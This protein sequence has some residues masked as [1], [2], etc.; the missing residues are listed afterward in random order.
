LAYTQSTLLIEGLHLIIAASLQNPS[1]IGMV[2]PVSQ[3]NTLYGPL[4][5]GPAIVNGLS[6]VPHG[7][8]DF[9]LQA[10]IAPNAGQDMT[11]VL[12]G[13]FHNALNNISTPMTAVGIGAPGVAWLDTAIKSLTL[14]TALPPLSDP[15]IESVSID[16]M[17]LDFAC[18]TCVTKPMASSDITAK[19]NLPFK[20]A[21]IKY[22]SQNIQ[23]LDKNKAVIGVLQ[24]PYAACVV[25]GNMVSTST[26]LSELVIDEAALDLIYPTFI[27]DLATGT[28]YSLGLRGTVDS[29]LDL[30]P[31]GIVEIKGIPLDVETPMA[32]LNNLQGMK[33]MYQVYSDYVARPRF[34]MLES[35]IQIHNPTNLTLNLGTVNFATAAAG[36][37]PL[38]TSTIGNLTLVPGDNVVASETYLDQSL[39]AAQ[40]LHYNLVA[41]GTNY[42]LVLTGYDQTS[43]NA[44]LNAGL[45]VMKSEVFLPG[46]LAGTNISQPPYLD[47]S[48]KT[49][50]TTNTDLTFKATATFQSPYYGFPLQMVDPGIMSVAQVFNVSFQADG[51]VLFT[52]LSGPT[53]TVQGTEQVTVTFDVQVSGQALTA[54]LKPLW[55]DIVNY[56]QA[57]GNIP[58]TFQLAADMIF[59]NNGLVEPIDISSQSLGLPPSNVAVRPDFAS[60]LDAFPTA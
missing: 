23:I 43:S 25:N 18:D 44:A 12:Q 35:I 40:T 36:E 10:T 55:V 48:L 2:I 33:Y 15:P 1:T 20:L 28:T 24:T 51:T 39:P 58:V 21:P 47:W 31:F 7:K 16:A 60:I 30:G 49:T 59:N 6:L 8:S 26:P 29:K 4:T 11:P 5:L 46:F 54:G 32:G 41:L 17:S 53:Y 14:S 13:I 37:G 27:G 45:A 38:G 56:G 3:F 57:H 9:S 52:F 42:T 34:I 50:P 19:T 22:L